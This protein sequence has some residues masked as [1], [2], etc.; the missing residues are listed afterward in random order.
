MGVDLRDVERAVEVQRLADHEVVRL[1][2]L[3]HLQEQAGHGQRHE[4]YRDH[5]DGGENARAFA[6][7]AGFGHH[8]TIAGAPKPAR[9]PLP[10]DPEETMGDDVEARTFTRADRTRYR[11]KV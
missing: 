1:V 10:K 6:A 3:R 8:S 11:Q 2:A 5:A 9:M 7:Q 4:G